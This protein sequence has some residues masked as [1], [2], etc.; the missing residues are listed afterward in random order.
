MLGGIRRNSGSSRTSQDSL[1]KTNNNISHNSCHSCQISD[2][3][4]AC[5]VWL[6]SQLIQLFLLNGIFVFVKT[7]YNSLKESMCRQVPSVKHGQKVQ[8]KSMNILVHNP[9]TLPLPVTDVAAVSVLESC[10]KGWKV[11]STQVM[12]REYL[13]F[14]DEFQVLTLQ[15]APACTRIATV[16]RIYCNLILHLVAGYQF[17]R[18]DMSICVGWC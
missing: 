14:Q 6:T 15:S 4:S 12:G 13:Y 17:G 18:H 16:Y 5:G 7:E 10:P 9:S 2:R 1:G 8:P 3:C 11:R